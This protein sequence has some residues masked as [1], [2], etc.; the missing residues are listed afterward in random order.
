MTGYSDWLP[1]YTGFIQARLNKIQGLFKDILIISKALY[2]TYYT[3]SV[4]FS[5]RYCD[6]CIQ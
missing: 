1:A 3:E 5:S 6:L 2:K 4:T